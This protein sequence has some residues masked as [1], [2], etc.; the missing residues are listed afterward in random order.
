MNGIH[1]FRNPSSSQSWLDCAQWGIFKKWHLDNEVPIPMGDMTHANRGT[2]LHGVIET[3]LGM[4]IKKPDLDPEKL[5]RSPLVTKL[6]EHDEEQVGI[7]FRAALR[8]LREHAW[9]D[10]GSVGLEVKV[11]LTYEH[12]K[13]TVDLTL[14]VPSVVLVVA[15]YKFG[16][17]EVLASSSQNRIYAASLVHRLALKGITFP[18]VVLAIIQ[19][20]LKQDA[21]TENTTPL[22]LDR[23]RHFVEVT[24]DNQ[25]AGI[26]TR[27]ASTPETCTFCP[28]KPR[29][30]HNE[31]MVLEVLD[32]VQAV[33]DETAFPET[34]EKM[35]RAKKMIENALAL[36]REIIFK[37]PETFPNFGRSS[38][39]NPRGFDFDKADE[40]TI[41]H[42]LR[43]NCGV[44]DPYKLKSVAQIRKLLPDEASDIEDFLLPQ[45]Y[46]DVLTLK[47]KAS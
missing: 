28:F 46:A 29:C 37:D 13:G 35:Y 38:R 43:V 33:T 10:V 26:D 39:K 41:A 40:A 44:D 12:A 2:M 17:G 8:L 42:H 34:L 14:I 21:I 20:E 36:A 32:D 4:V 19:P 30:K 15:D 31:Q 27:G 6:D 11:S 16:R 18:K 7:A 25:Q 3:L 1:A 24:V 5:L 22:D 47:K 45:G 23:F 9:P